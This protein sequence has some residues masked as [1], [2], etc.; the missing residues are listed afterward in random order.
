MNPPLVLAFGDSLVAG[1]GLGRVDAF[2]AQLERRLAAARP[3]TRVR[4]EGVSGETTA[5]GVQRLPRVL[6][7]LRE[8]PDLAILELG[9]NDLIRGTGP[10]RTRA[11]LDAMLRELA[12]CEIPVLLAAMQAPPILGAFAL[13]FDAIYPALATAHGVPVAPFFPAGVM[14]HPELVQW[15]GIHPNARGVAAIA[16][17]LAPAVLAALD[18]P[19]IPC[20]A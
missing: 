12:R 18:R 4:G 14:G 16:D 1:Y 11:N 6:A 13:A 8:R 19:A 15:D 7:R 9:A 5:G 17:A 20:A 3:G 2:P 10:D